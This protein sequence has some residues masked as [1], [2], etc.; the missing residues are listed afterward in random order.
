VKVKIGAYDY[1]IVAFQG[2]LSDVES[3]QGLCRPDTQT[4]YI[5]SRKPP[6]YQAAILIHELIH[7]IFASINSDRVNLT[8]E[9][10]CMTLDNPLAALIRDNPELLKALTA[11]L[12]KNR[13]I[14]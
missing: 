3:A 5:D 11:A 12:T 4:I 9:D 1:R 7:A 10:V 6:Q 13:P 14:V 2:I 8:E